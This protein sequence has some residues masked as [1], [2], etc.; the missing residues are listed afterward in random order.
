MLALG[1]V[2]PVYQP[3][4]IGVGQDRGTLLRGVS[5]DVWA[6]M[7]VAVEIAVAPIPLAAAVLLVGVFAL[8]RPRIV[9]PWALTTAGFWLVEVMTQAQV[10][11]LYTGAPLVFAALGVALAPVWQRGRAA[12]V[13]V[14]LV[15]AVVGWVSLALWVDAVMGWQKPRID[16]LT[17]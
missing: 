16:G 3:F 10:R 7:G 6:Q 1:T 4:L 12:K 9:L 8:R 11:Y 5:P 15:F 14:C 17:H 13:L 2:I